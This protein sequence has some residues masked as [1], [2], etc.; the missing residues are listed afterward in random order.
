M[1]GKP[2]FTAL[3]DMQIGVTI[4]AANTAKDCASGT[5]NLIYTSPT[6]GSWLSGVMAM[7]LGT[8]TASV[9]RLFLNNGSATTTA[10]NN[11]LISQVSLP[12]TTNTE[13]AGLSPL[14][15]PIPRALQD[16]TVGYRLYVLLGTAV[17][18]GW[19]FTPMASKWS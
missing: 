4:T 11:C 10:T 14:M 9:A 19:Q 2:R 12:A 13:V 7:P 17:S 6:G 1:A 3:P 16:M 15:L 8:N 18:A 5:V